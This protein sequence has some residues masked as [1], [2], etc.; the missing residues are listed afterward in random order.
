MVQ[1]FTFASEQA[2]EDALNTATITGK[3][4]IT[5]KGAKF[6]IHITDQ[7]G[8]IISEEAQAVLDR[9]EGL[10]ATEEQAIIDFVNAESESLGNSNWRL[11]DEFYCFSLGGANALTGF[12]A[13]TAINNGAVL[14]IEGAA[15]DGIN[16]FAT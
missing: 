13:K 3:F 16:T 9:L 2:L 4:A 5:A 8:Q 7:T 1:V 6:T 11:I 14:S 10:S 15:T 12:I